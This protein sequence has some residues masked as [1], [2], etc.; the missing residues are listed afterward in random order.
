MDFGA[1]NQYHITMEKIS[2]KEAKKSD[3]YLIAEKRMSY[4]SMMKSKREIYKSSKNKE[5]FRRT[6]F[7]NQKDHCCC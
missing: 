3:C 4:D 5:D 6:V 7:M 2:I 1:G